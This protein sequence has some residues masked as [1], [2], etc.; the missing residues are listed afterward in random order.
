MLLVLKLMLWSVRSLTRS[1]RVVVLEN[2]A[3]R[4]QLAIAVRSGRRPKLVAV[5]RAFW[6]ALRQVWTDWSASLAIVK[7][8]TVVAWHRRAYR[9]Y[10][11]HLCRKPGRPRTDEEPRE[12]IARMVKENRWGAP[13][14][15][16]E[17][18]KLGFRV[19]ERT[20]SRYV[21]ALRP[22][23]PA[24][25]SWMTFLT[26]HR[27]VLAAMDFFTVPTVTFRLLYVLLVIQHCRRKVLHVNV[28]PHPTS[29]W[30]RQQLREAFPFDQVPRYLL[31]D[32]D[33]IFSA[34]V[35]QAVTGM[36]IEPLRTSVQSPW[37]NGVAERWVGTCRR[38]LLD[39]VIVLDE[40]HL[41][42]LLFEFLD[43]Y[44]NDRTH[45]ALGKDPPCERAV[46]AR[47]SPNA[48]VTSVPRI[49]GLHHRYDWREAA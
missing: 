28:T 38:E 36:Q 32:H 17:L 16:G 21:R 23:R 8:A 41:R 45:L 39:H 43:Y 12:L 6:I 27:D 14:I 34:E 2:L 31:M 26:N 40:A 10:W 5:D 46:S 19:S 1:R 42:R 47:S 48:K 25:T 9:T 30:V 11:R 33:S 7:P 37:Q 22:R 13:R 49:G 18:L 20:V 3:L 35:V 15:H 4:Q 24:G 29:A 44:H